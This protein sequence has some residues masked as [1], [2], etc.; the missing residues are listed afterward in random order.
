MIGAGS[1]E[2]RVAFDPPSSSADGYGGE[3]K[4]WNT[5]A[6]VTRRAHFLWLRGG[7]TVQAARLAGRQ[8]VVA[9]VRKDS[10]TVTIDGTWRMRDLRRDVTYAVRSVVESNDRLWLEITCEAGVAL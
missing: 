10:G 8:P 3:T 2:E 7:E 4:S 1:L 9:T 6:A 5:G